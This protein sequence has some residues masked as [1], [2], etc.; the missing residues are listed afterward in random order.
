ML[1]FDRH[2]GVR[3]VAISGDGAT[4]AAITHNGALDIWRRVERVR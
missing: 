2:H 4:V 3:R 1:P